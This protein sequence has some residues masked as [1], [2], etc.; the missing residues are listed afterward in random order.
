M[1]QQDISRRRTAIRLLQLGAAGALAPYAAGIPDARAETQAP[2]ALPDSM[3]HQ[4]AAADGPAYGVPAATE[5][6]VVRR[7]REPLALPSA[8]SAL[9]PL[10]DLH[11]IITPN[12][13]HYTRDHGGTPTID[14]DNHNLLI[15]GMV[16]R[17]MLFSMDDVMRFPSVT[18]IH[19]LECSGNS[20][21]WKPEQ[22]K[23]GWTAQDTHGLLSCCEWT[24]VRLA[25]VLDEVGLQAGAKWMLA[26]GADAAG[27]TRSI[28]LAKALDDAILAYAQNGERLR[29]E[30]GYPLRLLL[31]G[32]EGNM[33]I[34]WLH[35]LKIG[36]QPFHT[37]EETSRYTGL[38]PDGSARQFVFVMEVK[39][40]ITRPSG[41]QSLRKP[42]F[43]EI[44]GIAWSGNGS[45]RRVDVSADGGTTWQQ[46]SL[47]APVLPKCLTRFR[48]PWQWVGGPAVLVSRAV[49]DTGAIQPT[50]AALTAERGT[51]SV[52]HYNGIH[53]W[54][55]AA[56]GEVS[57]AV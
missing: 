21:L 43:H 11:G 54:R 42:G 30:Q 24:G 57:C 27:M 19:F 49:D 22:V 12:G 14:P 36:D 26:E 31:P 28:P 37:R 13:L 51:N 9:T 25:D 2:P 1:R 3:Q 35:R 47:Q 5:K 23:P 15:H 40:V 55:I 48:L 8:G 41:G 52:Y 4:G 38:L 7:F 20:P 6:A 17:P 32:Y 56:N 10:Q 29:P 39:S 16:R 44:S 34:K 45:I 53:P 46:A 50:R 18:A 33:N